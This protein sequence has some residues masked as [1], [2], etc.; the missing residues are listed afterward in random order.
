MAEQRLGDKVKQALADSTDS[1]PFGPEPE[2]IEPAP[3]P[4][5]VSRAPSFQP[6]RI[7]PERP[8][9]A[10]SPQYYHG[11]DRHVEFADQGPSLPI[12]PCSRQPGQNLNAPFPMSIRSTQ[13][14]DEYRDFVPD[15]AS[16]YSAQSTGILEDAKRR[17]DTMEH[18]SANDDDGFFSS[19]GCTQLFFAD[20]AGVGM[21][22]TRRITGSTSP[23]S[24]PSPSAA[25]TGSYE[26]ASRNVGGIDWSTGFSGHSGLNRAHRGKN[27]RGTPRRHI[28][29]MSEHKGAAH[30][31]PVSSSVPE[32]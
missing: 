22:G 7:M 25:S 23:L 10:A 14:M 28:R 13:S 2:I 9:V 19:F 29:T 20:M 30:I 16:Q 3:T 8:A 17:L 32:W 26:S 31:G 11:H 21:P 6:R 18:R 24:V 5:R 4:T 1:D 12:L 27:G 15:D